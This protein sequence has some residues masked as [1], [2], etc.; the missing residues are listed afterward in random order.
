VAA[1]AGES[2]SWFSSTRVSHK[3][4]FKKIDFAQPYRGIFINFCIRGGNV[5]GVW[6]ELNSKVIKTGILAA[7]SRDGS[8]IN[9]TGVGSEMD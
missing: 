9:G 3:P 8:C 6:V 1:K 7:N 5:R 4:E 2:Q